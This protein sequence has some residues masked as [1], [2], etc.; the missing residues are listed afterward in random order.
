LAFGLLLAAAAVSATSL[1]EIKTVYVFPM[2]N[3][4]DQYLVSKLTQTHTL[5]VVADPKLAD[6]VFTDSIGPGFETAF[7]QRLLDAKVD[8]N[9]PPPAFHSSRNTVFLVD[10][11]KHVV[12]SSFMAEKDATAK[13]L[14]KA[15]KRLVVNLQKDMGILPPP[16]VSVA[17]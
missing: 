7:N 14:E 1:S 5:Q 16:V 3:A 4:L 10:K 13:E 8:P 11:T 2:R 17:R 12:W 9:Q 15:V 6:A